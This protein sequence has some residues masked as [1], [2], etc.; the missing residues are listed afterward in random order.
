MEASNDVSCIYEASRELEKSME[1]STNSATLRNLSI[2]KYNPSGIDKFIKYKSF[3]EE[4][5]EVVLTKPLKP[6]M[7]LNYLKNS[8]TGEAKQLLANY[9]LGNQL[10][11]ALAA[12]E[13]NYSKPEFVIA[14]VYRSIKNLPDIS[15][16]KNSLSKAKEQVN[17]LKIAICTLKS[18]GYEEELLNDTNLQNLF[19]LVDIEGKVPLEAYTSWC[20]EKKAIKLS[21]KSPNI[22]N[23]TLFYEKMVDIQYD[24]VYLRNRMEE[25][26][27]GV[28]K[29]EDTTNDQIKRRARRGKDEQHHANLL[30]NKTSETS[31]SSSKGNK[32]N[33]KQVFGKYTKAYCVFH[34]AFGHGTGYCVGPKYDED[35]KMAQVKRHKLCKLCLKTATHSEKDCNAEYKTCLVCKEAHHVNLHERK[36]VDEAFRKLKEEKRKKD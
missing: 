21:G 19:L 4:F 17:T 30:A 18:M 34:D 32:N 7:K 10:N 12:L 11:D 3:M 1:Q 24:A 36:D 20:S 29:R 16:F 9:T 27:R 8:V 28:P 22:E 31:E 5:T 2:E 15:S 33:R 23:F 13:N 26:N 35:Y 6:L 14:E 25:I